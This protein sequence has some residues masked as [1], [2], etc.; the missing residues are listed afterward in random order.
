MKTNRQQLL[1]EDLSTLIDFLISDKPL[2]TR[3]VRAIAPA[4]LR[5]WLIDGNLNLLANELGV[6]FEL[7]TFDTSIVFSELDQTSSAIFY[8]TGGIFIGGIPTQELYVSDK[9]FTG[10][11]EIS[12]NMTTVNLTLSKFINSKRIFFKGN[13]FTNE[14]LI[15]FASNKY[16]GVHY[17]E[18]R[19]KNWQ[20]ELE[21]ANKYC[22]LGNPNYD[23]ESKLIELSDDPNGEFLIVV[24]YAEE[25]VE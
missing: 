25:T 20:T 16:G 24:R 10:K 13:S 4:I 9:A 7:P 2:Q 5:K 8:M 15:Q 11:P 18:K 3:H 14:Q 6:K 12:F 17:D 22:S 21:N 1:E 23:N 19:N